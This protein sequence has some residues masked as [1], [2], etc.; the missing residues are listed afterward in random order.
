MCLAIPGKVIKIEEDIA[1]VSY[2]E[3]KKQAK[4]LNP[5][6]KIGDYVIVQN[7]LILQKVP[8]NEA[9]ESIRLWKKVLEHED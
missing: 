4:L 5:D 3:E 9:L 7:R 6:I 8:E 2:G 1:T